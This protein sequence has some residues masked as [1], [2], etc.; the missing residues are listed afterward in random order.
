VLAGSDVLILDEVFGSHLVGATHWVGTRW[1]AYATSTGKVLLAQ[2]SPKQ[3]RG[4]LPARLSLAAQATRS[5]ADFLAELDKVKTRGYAT[6][7]EELE[8]GFAAVGAPIFNHEGAAIAA[9][10]V[11]GPRSRL[12]DKVIK[13]L[14]PRVQAAAA[15]I[16]QQLGFRP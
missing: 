4:L 7:V 9:V 8:T 11:G 14:T 5:R 15:A 12:S 2:L 16:S 3:L 13:Q 10:S 1:H 6:N